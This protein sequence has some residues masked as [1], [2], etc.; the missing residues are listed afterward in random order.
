MT[1]YTDI[2]SELT[3]AITDMNAALNALSFESDQVGYIYNYLN[4]AEKPFKLYLEKYLPQAPCDALFLGMNPGPWGTAQTGVPF[5]DVPSVRDWMHIEADV[6]E[7]AHLSP[8]RPVEGFE[9]ERREVSGTRLW[10]WI[11]ERWGTADHFFAHN[12][13][14][15]HCPLMFIHTNG[16]RNITPNRLIKNDRDVLYP[17]CDAML[18]A[19]ITHLQPTWCIAIGGYAEQAFKRSIKTTTLKP[20]CVKI[21]HP[22]PA[23]PAANNGWSTKV[24]E[25]LQQAG[26]ELPQTPHD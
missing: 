14:W 4:Y 6:G 8:K 19:L 15:S 20:R 11:E 16:S 1:R 5:G 26:F 9:L 25:Q 12:F 23:S 13:I 22:S 7:P 3:Q 18:G 24:E 10:G 17:I 21:L 2:D